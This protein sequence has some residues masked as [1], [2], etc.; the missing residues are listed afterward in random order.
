M[1]CLSDKTGGQRN[2]F[3]VTIGNRQRSAETD[4]GLLLIGLA[5]FFLTW[6]NLPTI[7]VYSNS[8]K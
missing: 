8:S 2:H 3:D 5:T 6:S 7:D 4:A 1:E